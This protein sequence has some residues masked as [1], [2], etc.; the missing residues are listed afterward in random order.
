MPPAGKPQPTDDQLTLLQWWID[1]GATADK[2]VAQLNPPAKVLSAFDEMYGP[3]SPA[4]EPKPLADVSST[5]AQLQSDLGV[6]LTP[7][8]A[9]QPWLDC[10]ASLSHTFGDAELAKLGAIG[11]NIQALNLSG[12]KVTNAGLAA[13]E[14]MPNLTRLHLEKTAITDAGLQHVAKLRKIQYLNLYGTGM[15]DAGLNSLKGLPKLHNLYLWQTKVTPA[16]AKAFADAMTDKQKIERWQKDIEALQARI[17]NQGVEV[18]QST[19]QT[20]AGGAAPTMPAA[21]KPTAAAPASA[22]INTIC[23]IKGLPIDP[24]KTVVYNGKTIAFC[25]DKC[26]AQFNKNPKPVLRKLNIPVASK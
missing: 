6:V 4:A 21:G 3:T 2:K 25:C 20:L 7:L 17:K 19:Q 26:L 18:V 22:P 9:D 1:S 11:G 15:T 5:V 16:S 24:T 8:A 10:N 13:L 23:P 14:G 12:S